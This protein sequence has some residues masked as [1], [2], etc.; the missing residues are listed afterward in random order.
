MWKTYDGL[1][2]NIVSGLFFYIYDRTHGIF[3]WHPER[4][5]DTNMLQNLK[6]CTVDDSMLV[7][8]SASDVVDALTEAGLEGDKFRRIG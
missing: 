5:I 2:E 7:R 8:M 6:L 3:P 4:E 1:A